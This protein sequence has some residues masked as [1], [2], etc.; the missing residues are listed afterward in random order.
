MIPRIL[1]V[2]LHR[3]TRSGYTWALL[4]GGFFIGCGRLMEHNGVQEFSYAD[5]YGKAQGGSPELLYFLGGSILAVT[6]LRALLF[7]MDELKT[8][9]AKAGA[10]D[11]LLP[12]D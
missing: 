9:R 10:K 4:A 12:D 11:T 6:L 8:E 5:K 2:F 1:V 7:R 3:I